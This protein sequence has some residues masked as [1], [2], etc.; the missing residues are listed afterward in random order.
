MLLL[1][2]PQEWIAFADAPFRDVYAVLDFQLPGRP[3]TWAD[4]QLAD[5][6]HVQL[7]LIPG[8][9]AEPAELWVL[10]GDAVEQFDALVREANGR[11]LAR[12]AFAIGDRDGKRI[13][14]L[15]ARPGKTTMPVLVLENALACRSYLRLPNLY[16]PLGYSLRPPLRR[17]AV[18]R[19]LADD[20]DQ[21]VWLMPDGGESFVAQSLP[22]SAFR[23]LADWV[24]YVLDRDSAESE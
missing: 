8:A 12:L 18:R 4:D 5:K 22:D 13:A 9:A 17:D 7:R 19:L 11:L 1:R 2:P 10:H 6:L 23:P 16:L 3:V 24:D 21:V 14:V 20:A 15:R